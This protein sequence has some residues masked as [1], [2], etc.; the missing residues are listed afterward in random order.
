MPILARG[1]RSEPIPIRWEPGMVARGFRVVWAGH[2]RA[3][4]P[5]P[6]PPPRP[7]PRPG[8]GGG[9]GGFP[10]FPNL[11]PPVPPEVCDELRNVEVECGV[12]DER[13]VT[14]D[15][16]VA[17]AEVLS[18]APHKGIA[19]GLVSVFCRPKPKA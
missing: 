6:P 16:A 2:V 8:G 11:T 9:G 17:L 7:R 18:A 19:F 13:D 3:G 12:A 10:F 15:A 4:P 1:F 5:P 14:L